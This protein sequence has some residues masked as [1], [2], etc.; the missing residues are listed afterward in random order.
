M[1]AGKTTYL[2]KQICINKGKILAVDCCNKRNSPRDLSNIICG[3][4]RDKAY[5]FPQLYILEEYKRAVDMLN[6][7]LIIFDEFHLAQVFGVDNII[8]SFMEETKKVDTIVCGLK[9]DYFNN[10]KEFDIWSKLVPDKSIWLDSFNSCVK[11]K[12][13]DKSVIYTVKLDDSTS[14]DSRV[15]DN[16]GNICIECKEKYYSKIK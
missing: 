16:Y 15:G 1:W 11:C 5:S 3:R 7:T 4:Y 13:K 6:P 8:L 12:K 10:F 14:L 9:Y 2:E